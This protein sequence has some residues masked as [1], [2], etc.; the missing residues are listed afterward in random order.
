MLEAKAEPGSLVLPS[1]QWVRLWMDEIVARDL[2]TELDGMTRRPIFNNIGKAEVHHRE[3]IEALLTSAG[4]EIPDAPE[5]GNYPV[6][7]LQA[8]YTEKLTSGKES[9]LAAFKSGEAFELQDIAELEAALQTEGLSDAEKNLLT[10]LVAASKRH[11]AAFQHKLG[12]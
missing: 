10:A 11:L 1:E 7:D 3:M 2:Y 6:N 4:I 5:A 9:E 8:F 12:K